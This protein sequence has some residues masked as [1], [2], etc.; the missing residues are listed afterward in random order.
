[1]AENSELEKSV[2]NGID[3]LNINST[4]GVNGSLGPDHIEDDVN[5]KERW[6]FPLNDLYKLGLK[7]Y[8]GK[9]T[10]LLTIIPY[11]FIHAK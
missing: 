5:N 10:H 11:A 7:F 4:N 6:G 9:R 2:I 1:M 8:K 3:N